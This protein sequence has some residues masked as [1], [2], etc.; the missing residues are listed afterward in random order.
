MGQRPSAQYR[1]CMEGGSASVQKEG[2][3]W[4]Q[5]EVCWYRERQRQHMLGD[6]GEGKKRDG[7]KKK[8]EGTAPETA[9]NSS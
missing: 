7:K 3:R 1:T 8:G 5:E 6:K 4:Q 9:A 2:S